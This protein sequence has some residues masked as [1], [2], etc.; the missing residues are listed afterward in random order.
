MEI[1]GGFR[2]LL[3]SGV[4]R[5]RGYVATGSNFFWKVSDFNGQSEN[6]DINIF[7]IMHF[8]FPIS[9]FPIEHFI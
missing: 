5:K 4:F 9:H 6:I 8:F 1:R 3:I 2:S 7:R